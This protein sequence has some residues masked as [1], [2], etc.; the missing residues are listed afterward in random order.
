[1]LIQACPN[2]PR[3][4]GDHPALPVS[5]A[6]VARD[7][8][9]VVAVGAR[10]LH[11]HPKD[12]AGADS[13]HPAHVAE[14]VTAVR[15]AVPGV[16]IGVT[17]GAWALPDPG[18]R[19]EV[20]RRWT[21]LPDHAS[22][23]WH[24]DGADD[25]AAALLDRGVQIEAGLWHLEGVAAWQASPHR[26]SCLRVLLEL[27]DGL[28]GA[29]AEAEAARLL[30]AVGKGRPVLLH[31]EGSSCWP[32]LRS[33]VRR[34]LDTRIGLEDVLSLPDGA[35]APDNA[36]LVTAATAIVAAVRAVDGAGG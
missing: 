18:E 17:T 10:E 6:A 22:L 25:V 33:A 1:M 36:A 5:P 15:A 29:A 9:A 24:E 3:R 16:P 8:A 28:D 21:V 4:P 23:N 14:V 26:D 11:V 34:G 32:V 7:A 27:P 31:G 20:I 19:V 30:A 12:D 35:P 2:G 13:L